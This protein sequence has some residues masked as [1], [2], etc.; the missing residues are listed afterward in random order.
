MPKYTHLL[1]VHLNPATD[2]LPTKN[3]IQNLWLLFNITKVNLYKHLLIAPGS[4]ALISAAS[5]DGVILGG[6][7]SGGPDVV[8]YGNLVLFLKSHQKMVLAQEG[9]V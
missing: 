5:K 6:G 8:P 7:V 1:P 3:D 2:L 9:P 4:T